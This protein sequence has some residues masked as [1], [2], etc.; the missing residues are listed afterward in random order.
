MIVIRAH[1]DGRVIVPDESVGLPPDSKVMVLIDGDG[2]PV[3]PALEQAT[4]DYYEQQS[5]AEM[6][7]DQA[8]GGAVARDGGKAWE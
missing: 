2:S 3:D 4:K 8:W 1:F 6:A 7:E 5:A